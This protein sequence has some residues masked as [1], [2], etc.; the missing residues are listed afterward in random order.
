LIPADAFAAYG[1]ARDMLGKFVRRFG[2]AAILQAVV[3]ATQLRRFWRVDT[4]Q[5][6]ALPMDFERVAVDDRGLSSDC[7]GE[8]RRREEECERR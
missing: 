3:T 6:N 5:A 1:P 2:S 8:C 4:R 7:F